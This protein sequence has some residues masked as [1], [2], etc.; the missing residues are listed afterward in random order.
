MKKK[1]KR[2]RKNKTMDIKINKANLGE[3]KE[4]PKKR[5]ERL[6][7]VFILRQNLHVN[8]EEGNCRFGVYVSRVNSEIYDTMRKKKKKKK[9]KLFCSLVRFQNNITH[10]VYFC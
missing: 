4:K 6:Q 7:I 8:G 1:K 5:E 9:D 2:K 10:L 3:T